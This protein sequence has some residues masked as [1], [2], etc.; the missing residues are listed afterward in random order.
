VSISQTHSPLKERIAAVPVGIERRRAVRHPCGYRTMLQPISLREIAALPVQVRDLSATGL[1][2]LSR[3]PMGPGTFLF[4]ELQS[5]LNGTTRR[6]RAH[7]IH[8]T[9]QKNGL[10]LLGCALTDELTRT[11]LQGLL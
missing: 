8:A 2:L 1:G 5:M 6:L 7:V 4:V 11:E 9:R 10:W 3:T